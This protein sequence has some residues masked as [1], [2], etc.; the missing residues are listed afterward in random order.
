MRERKIVLEDHVPDDLILQVDENLLRIVYDNLLSNALKY[1]REGGTIQLDCFV[2]HSQVVLGVKN[3]GAG[4][5]QERMPQL[6]KK[7]SRLDA[8]E[9][10]AKKGSGLG[11]YICKEIVGKLGGEI[12]ADSKVGEWV[13]F[14]FSLPK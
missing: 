4:I 1:G 10:A 3:Q 14:S 11:L 12:W 8:P 2:N 13:K 6:F 5:P 7:F 9:Y